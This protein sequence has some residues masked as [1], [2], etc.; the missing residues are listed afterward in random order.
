MKGFFIGTL[1]GAILVSAVSY[2]ADLLPPKVSESVKV[3]HE[4]FVQAGGKNVKTN[5]WLPIEVD[6]RGR[7]ICSK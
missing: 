7:V 5:R 3:M 4:M 1:C 2:A 6:S